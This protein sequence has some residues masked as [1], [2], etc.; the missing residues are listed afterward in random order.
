MADGSSPLARGLLKAAGVTAEAIR[1]IPARAGFTPHPHHR[2]ATSPDHPRSR[3]VYAAPAL[4]ALKVLGSSPLARGLLYLG[5]AIKE[6]AGDHPRSRGVYAHTAS[7]THAWS[8]SSPLARGLRG[9]PCW[10]GTATGII[11]A[12][13]GFTA[14]WAPP[15]A[16]IGDHPR[17]RGVY[18]GLLG[19][20]VA[21]VGSSPL[22]RG[23]P[24]LAGASTDV[25]RIIPARAGFTCLP[26]RRRLRPRDHPR[27]RGVYPSSLGKIRLAGVVLLHC[28]P[29]ERSAELR[30]RLRRAAMDQVSL[31]GLT[32]PGMGDVP[33]F[34]FP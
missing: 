18:G 14:T 17:S 24:R 8:G 34:F 15:T 23:L 16:S 25:G 30:K 19:A 12:R 5:G 3:G 33:P 32:A 10:R 27:S 7:R 31:G 26:R 11:P 22:A 1:I 4:D 29:N 2:A 6:L 20:I 9:L 13:A 28:L 21:S